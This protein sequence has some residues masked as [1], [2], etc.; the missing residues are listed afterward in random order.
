MPSEHAT[1]AP[2]TLTR[3][4]GTSFQG[5]FAERCPEA[6]AG[7][8]FYAVFALFPFLLLLVAAS[9][10][11]LESPDTQ[12]RVLSAVLRFLP[13]SGEIVTENMRNLVGSR[14]TAGVVSAVGLLWAATG[15][16]TTVVR[17]VDRAWRGELTRNVL[18]SRL[19]ALV[20]VF[21]LVGL[22]ALLL[23]ARSFICIPTGWSLPGPLQET[24]A[25]ACRLPSRAAISGFI[26]L[27]LTLLYRLVPGTRVRW[28]EAALGGAVGILAFRLVTAGF[29]WYLDSGL[30]R[31]N[32]VYGSLGALV[33]LL[34]WIYIVAA[35]VLYGAHLSAATAAHTRG[36]PVRIRGPYGETETHADGG[37]EE[38]EPTEG[39]TE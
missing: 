29:T 6:A 18:L 11:L 4:V 35:I 2:R 37:R 3:I 34:S 23:L 22:A 36:L 39:E 33:A 26:F 5:F 25:I 9:S 27:T 38:T 7:I 20:I 21:G 24:V 28:R 32:V 17:N 14:A 13:V 15:V 10:F 19:V 1:S 16:F 8:G 12:E 31:Y 30:A